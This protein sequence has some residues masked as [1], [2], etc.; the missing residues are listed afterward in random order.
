MLQADFAGKSELLTLSDNITLV[1][2]SK[3]V[4]IISS[5]GGATRDITLPDAT[6]L[7]EGAPLFYIGN[8]DE[9][10]DITVKDNGGNTIATL[11]V[12]DVVILCLVDNSTANGTWVYINKTMEMDFTL[13]P[14]GWSIENYPN[15]DS[16]DWVFGSLISEAITNDASA[17]LSNQYGKL[18]KDDAIDQTKIV[19]VSF[20]LTVDSIQFGGGADEYFFPLCI[21]TSSDPAD[22]LA[23]QLIQV[24]IGDGG[25]YYDICFRY[26][27]TS[28]GAF[29]SMNTSGAWVGAALS[30]FNIDKNKPIKLKFEFSVSTG[31]WRITLEERWYNGSDLGQI[32]SDWH[33]WNDTGTGSDDGYVNIGKMQRT[34]RYCEYSIDGITY[35]EAAP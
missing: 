21:G 2:G 9:T 11:S 35:S 7:E 33:A 8:K 25:T 32:Q 31:N 13:P 18:M 22:W 14:S 10:Y 16:M 4:Q 27:D 23:D 26:Y 30:F 5:A 1:K 34:D 6:T 15:S 3:R 28:S 20:D 29:I 24:I 19:E 17:A 12:T